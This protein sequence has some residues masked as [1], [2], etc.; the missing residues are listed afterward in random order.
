MA[1]LPTATPDG[2]ELVAVR[3]SS[4]RARQRLDRATASQIED[5]V[6]VSSCSLR[7]PHVYLILAEHR[8]AAARIPG[9]TVVTRHADPTLSWGPA[10]G[11]ARP[12][13]GRR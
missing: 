9:V 13:T 2:R 1:T 11:T 7:W 12:L 8:D 4:H 10:V 5:W 3:A 6:G